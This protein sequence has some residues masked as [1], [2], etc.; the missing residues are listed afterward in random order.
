M[1]FVGSVV[2]LSP[3][4]PVVGSS[5]NRVSSSRSMVHSRGVNVGVSL[6]GIRAMGMAL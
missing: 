4:L 2:A 1:A 6:V 5:L 3:S